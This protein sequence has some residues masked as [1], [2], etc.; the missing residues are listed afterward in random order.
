MHLNTHSVWISNF[1]QQEISINIDPTNL[2]KNECAIIDKKTVDILL[3]VQICFPIFFNSYKD[4]KAKKLI[5]KFTLL[6][7]YSTL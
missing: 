4:I 1:E 6:K 2:S 5:I 7:V 3:S